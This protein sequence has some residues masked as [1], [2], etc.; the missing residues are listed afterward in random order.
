MRKWLLVLVVVAAVVA[1]ACQRKQR[2]P[3]GRFR[4]VGT[5]VLDGLAADDTAGW[6]TEAEVLVSR[7][8][9]LDVVEELRRNGTELDPELLRR[10]ASARR[11]PDTR[12][13]ELT[14]RLDDARLAADTCN[15]LLETYL[16][17][18]F[19]R[20][21]AG[22]DMR[23]KQLVAQLDELEAA[24]RADAG[25]DPVTDEL[26]RTTVSRLAEVELSARTMERDGHLLDACVVPGPARS[27]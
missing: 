6:G 16:D 8:V 22:A 7:A 9:I 25:R 15:M 13:L 26:Y 23:Q 4:A 2:R 27:R 12:I 17:R 1:V 14:V 18:R 21:R 5:I 19:F 10:A 24:R 11:R 3:E 20:A